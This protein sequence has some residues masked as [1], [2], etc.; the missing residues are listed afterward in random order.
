MI[1]LIR[2]TIPAADTSYLRASI[3]TKGLLPTW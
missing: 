3:L 2:Q 1:N